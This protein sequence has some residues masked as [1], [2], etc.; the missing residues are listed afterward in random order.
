VTD[1]TTTPPTLAALTTRFGIGK[2]ITF[3]TGHGGLPRCKLSGTGG[4]AEIY[5]LGATLTSFI[6]TGGSELLFV[7]PKSKY[8]PGKAIRGGVPI[9]FPWFGTIPTKPELPQHGV[10]RNAQWQVTSTDAAADGSV[11]ITLTLTASDTTRKLW[12]NDFALTFTVII[13]PTG[14]LLMSL[15]TENRSQSPFVFEDALHTYFAVGD[16]RR[17]VVDGL[18]N[19]DYIDKFD[20]LTRKNQGK[21][22]VLLTGPTD[23]VYLGVTAPAI[24][25]DPAG[26]AIRVKK[27][28]SRCTVVW[29]PW[30]PNAAKMADLG[31][32]NWPGFI[33]IEACNCSEHAIHLAPGASH[34]TT[35][36]VAVSRE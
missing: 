6:P 23:R 33:C 13:A 32:E 28:G 17:V 34:T 16:V 24:I 10:A 31:Q 35:C 21:D 11:M 8:E 26:R 15:T 30:E 9:I 4:T 7:S 3:D 20:N 5:L 22:P 25:H 14:E 27:R 36:H 1:P 2:A 29:N 18:E 19:A 12:P